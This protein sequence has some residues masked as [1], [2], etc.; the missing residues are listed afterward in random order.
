MTP[1]LSVFF[2][3]HSLASTHLANFSL[4]PFQPNGEAL[5]MDSPTYGPERRKPKR[6]AKRCEQ[7]CV[8]VVTRMPL[9][10][11]YG[12]TTW[13]VWVEFGLSLHWTKTSFKGETFQQVVLSKSELN[14][15]QD[16][17]L[18]S[19]ALHCTFF[20]TGLIQPA[21]LRIQDRH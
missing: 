7:N 14:H 2:E 1:W 13:A 12:L 19:S 11:V 18:S 15:R 17:F 20:S 4:T 16:I 6:W 10:L 3:L 9:V 5:V 8:A 21:H